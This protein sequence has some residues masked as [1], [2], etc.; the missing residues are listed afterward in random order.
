LIRLNRTTTEFETGGF[1]GL[2]RIVASCAQ[3]WLI[4]RVRV[5]LLTLGIVLLPL[6]LG[7]HLSSAQTASEYQVK[8]AYLYN[9]AK[10]VEWPSGGFPSATAPIRLCVLNDSSFQSEL[11]QIVK[12]KTIISG[13][14]YNL[15]GRKY[16]DVSPDEDRQTALQQ[17]GRIFRLKLTW[18]FGAK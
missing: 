17:D 5:W 2:R 13:S 6:F 3:W 1:A 4:Q 11:V 14:V 18:D 8:A 12:S 7:E 15:L 10:F 16:F 9:F